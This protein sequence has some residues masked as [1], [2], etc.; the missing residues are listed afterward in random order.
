MNKSFYALTTGIL[1][2]KQQIKGKPLITSLTM[3]NAAFVLSLLQV[4]VVRDGGL[5]FSRHS[6]V[7]TLSI[8]TSAQAV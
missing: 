2:D 7:D 5:L 1:N 8:R 4:L 6:C 3:Y